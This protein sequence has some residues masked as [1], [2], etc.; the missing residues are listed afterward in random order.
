MAVSP[1]LPK[2]TRYIGSRTSSPSTTGLQ[3]GTWWY[4][5]DIGIF[6]YWDG[7]SIMCWGGIGGKGARA[8]NTIV[9][10]TAGDYS[11]NVTHP[12]FTTINYIL[13]ILCDTNP[14]VDPGNPVNAVITG[15]VVGF[16][17]VGVGGGTTLTANVYV[18]G[19]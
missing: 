19:W 2:R 8:S 14:I 6:C 7:T 17:I 12:P 9:V 11:I 10:A 15:N 4:R 13:D 5:S 3:V 18:T 1:P 16:T